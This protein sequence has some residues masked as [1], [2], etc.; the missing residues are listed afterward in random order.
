MD[1][2]LDLVYDDENLAKLSAEQELTNMMKMG[3]E[4]LNPR[5]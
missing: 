4:V 1:H 5:D 3:L 2:L